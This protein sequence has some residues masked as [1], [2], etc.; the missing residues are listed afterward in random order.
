MAYAKDT[1]V[2]QT[3]S[4]LEIEKVLARYGADQFM[5]G[6]TGQYA[7][8]GFVMVGR[9]VRITVPLPD[10]A[11]RKFWVTDTGRDRSESVA[12]KEWEQACKQKYRA[13][14]LVVKAKLEAVEAGITT[15]EEEFMAHLVLPGGQTVGQRLLPEI[16]EAQ[17]TGKMP[18][19]LP[20]LGD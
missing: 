20:N 3:A 7:V 2:S 5:Y 10:K 18:P 13:L 11:D 12:L 17:R 6:K 16:D 4:L 1:Q 9:Q 15:F 19:L 14:S 8:I